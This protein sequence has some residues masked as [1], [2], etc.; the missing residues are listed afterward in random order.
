MKVRQNASN[1]KMNLYKSSFLNDRPSLPPDMFTKPDVPEVAAT[2]KSIFSK[3]NLFRRRPT[4]DNIKPMAEEMTPQKYLEKTNR[5][6]TGS[7]GNLHY[8]YLTRTSAGRQSLFAAPV[9]EEAPND[10]LENTTIADLI[11]ALEVAHTHANTGWTEDAMSEPKRKFGTASLTPP[12]VSSLLTLFPQNL[13]NRSSMRRGSERARPPLRQS[14]STSGNFPLTQ[15]G[16]FHFVQNKDPPPYKPTDSP[17]PIKRR[18][19]VRPSNLSTPPGQLHSNTSGS[20]SSLAGAPSTILQRR[21][22]VRPSPLARTNLRQ[23]QE[24]NRNPLWRPAQLQQDS[25]GPSRHLSLSNLYDKRT[26]DAERKR[27]DSR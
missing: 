18:F 17:K 16:D 9:T 5:R 15:Y 27:T 2:N 25:L 1:P 19:S 10:L 20:S 8:N 4:L 14:L 21:L 12:K 24:S 22:S 13:P 23:S 7:L 11:R 3:I 26:D 6:R